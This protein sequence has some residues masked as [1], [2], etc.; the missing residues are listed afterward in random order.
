MQYYYQKMDA[1]LNTRTGG[2]VGE[3]SLWANEGEQ[4]TVANTKEVFPGLFVAGMAA[5]NVFGGPRMGPIFGGM[6]LSGK[7]VAEI[8]SSKAKNN[9][10]KWAENI[11]GYHNLIEEFRDVLITDCELKAERVTNIT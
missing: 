7:K 10:L 8:I 2:V 1:K 11:E 9:T 6:I 3:M 4:F 5:N